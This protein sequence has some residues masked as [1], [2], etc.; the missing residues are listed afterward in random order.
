MTPIPIAILGAN[1]KMGKR[2]IEL[3][4][5]DPK[6]KIAGTCARG[7]CPSQ[8]LLP[9]AVAIDFSHASA[10]LEYLSAAVALK[11]PLVL[12]T[13]GHDTHMLEEIQKAAKSIPILF[14]SNFS[15]GI[16][17]CKQTALKLAQSLG[18]AAQIHII[19]THHITKKDSP[20]GTALAIAKAADFENKG[21]I[22]IHSIREANVIGEHRIFFEWGNERIEIKHEALSRDAFAQGAL[23][24]AVFLIDK[25]PGLYTGNEFSQKKF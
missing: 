2:L 3:C 20:S 1:G 17:F 7:D 4:T 25:E 10:T 19:E 12:G 21:N 8:A 13:T 24:G 16:D 14:S 15:F 9:C 22:P 6:F 11:K 18:G 5:L 23:A